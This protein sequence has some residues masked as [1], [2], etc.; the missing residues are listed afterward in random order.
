MT[1]QGGTS[2]PNHQQ[3]I[4][5]DKTLFI[6]IPKTAGSF[7][8][9]KLYEYAKDQNPL[10][11]FGGHHLLREMLLH[12]DL[13]AYT[14][15][16]ICRN[17]YDRL[18]SAFKYLSVSNSLKHKCYLKALGDPLCFSEFVKGV[19]G[20]WSEDP[21]MLHTGKL[22]PYSPYPMEKLRKS[23]YVEKELVSNNKNWSRHIFHI[24]PQFN[25]VANNLPEVHDSLHIL[26]FESL[27]DDTKKFADELQLS[28]SRN[29]IA[30]YIKEEVIPF[31]L[32]PRSHAD[33]VSDSDLRLIND[34]Y[35]K[36]FDS[37]SYSR[38][39]KKVFVIPCNSLGEKKYNE[40]EFGCKIN[41]CTYGDQKFAQ[42][43]KRIVNEA[44]SL[45]IFDSVFFYDESIKNHLNFSS[46]LSSEDFAKVANSPKGG[47]YW[48][49]KPF[50]L[51]DALEKIDY[52]DLLLYADAGCS[53]PV[54]EDEIQINRLYQC[55]KHCVQS[56]SGILVFRNPYIE[57]QWT[58][59]SMLSFFK[60]LN[61]SSIVNTRQ[62]TA[63]RIFI[64]KSSESMMLVKKWLEVA[65]K[66]PLFFSDSCQI[67]C[68]SNDFLEHRHDQSVFSLVCKTSIVDESYDWD[69]IPVKATRIRG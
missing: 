44:S 30:N 20:I 58:S 5:A 67:P 1:N 43:R 60:S 24:L 9:K 69:M 50:V 23:K 41:F 40:C 68:E 57:G 27:V 53:F 45:D 31:I 7:F 59:K 62:F 32:P 19:Y 8:E 28:G 38:K 64:R 63:N 65:Y 2:N 46:M 56:M 17:P 61:N 49:W 26:R 3:I 11:P 55:I 52:G 21:E 51:L 54:A 10:L 34:I 22:L 47:G 25:F 39:G 48:I 14:I 42:S 15:F 36:D 35:S 6:H 18:I 16:T 12:W 4:P 66:N 13:S 33:S 29:N 37:F